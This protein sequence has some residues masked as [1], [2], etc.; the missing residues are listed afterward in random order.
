MKTQMHKDTFTPMFIAA[1]VTIA[2]TWKQTRC[3][4]RDES[5]KK[6]WYISTIEYSSVIRNYE[7]ESFVTIW[8]DLQSIMQSEISQRENV[9]YRMIS[10]IR[11]REKQQ[12]MNI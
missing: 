7:I 11:K 10:L 5:I 8:M 6:M 3:P 1:L 2:K 4:S 9:K 12:Q